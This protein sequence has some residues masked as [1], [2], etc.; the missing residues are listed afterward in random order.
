[1]IIGLNAKKQNGCQRS[2]YRCLKQEFNINHQLI[3]LIGYLEEKNS[4]I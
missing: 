2:N 4:E 1:M 3:A